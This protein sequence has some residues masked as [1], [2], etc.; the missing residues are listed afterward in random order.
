[1]PGL[2]PSPEAWSA[3]YT[4]MLMKLLPKLFRMSSPSDSDR[5]LLSPRL[6]STAPGSTEIER[7][8]WSPRPR[9]A[10]AEA[11]S[12][13]LRP[14]DG[15]NPNPA[16]KPSELRPERTISSSS[17]MLLRNQ[18]YPVR[19]SNQDPARGLHLQ[20]DLTRAK[21]QQI[22]QANSRL[23]C[24]AVG[25]S[26]QDQVTTNCTVLAPTEPKVDSPSSDLGRL[27]DQGQQRGRHRGQDP[28]LLT[29]IQSAVV[30]MRKH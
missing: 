30:Y 27:T 13:R 21:L 9:L 24:S 29:M 25:C 18:T 6:R 23:R 2:S 7:R 28:D 19:D 14:N 3:T 8:S 1:M 4:L 5:A 20:R 12:P 15:S 17:T 22:Y 11:S 26:H 16:D 10:P